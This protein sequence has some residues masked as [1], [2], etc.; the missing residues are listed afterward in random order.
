[1]IE[2]MKIEGTTLEGRKSGQRKLD[3][4]ILGITAYNTKFLLQFLLVELPDSSLYLK[5]LENIA[6]PIPL[7]ILRINDS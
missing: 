6:T 3:N 5:K 7:K 4:T 1:M 2:L